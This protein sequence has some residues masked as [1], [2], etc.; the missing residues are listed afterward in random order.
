MTGWIYLAGPLFTQAEV[1]FNQQLADRLRQQGY[2]VYLPQQECVGITEP[3]ALF[4]TCIRGLDGAAIVLV[5]LDGPDADSGSC[6]EMGYAYARGLPIVGLRTDFR[7]SGE[8]MGVNLMLTHSCASLILTTLTE[9]LAP[10]K[11]TY[12][13]PGQDV[14]SAVLSALNM[15]SFQG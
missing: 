12:L 5:I 8:H 14:L 2:Q 1:A 11:V 10:S 9:N 6:F 15:L 3:A 13:K 7:G 4:A